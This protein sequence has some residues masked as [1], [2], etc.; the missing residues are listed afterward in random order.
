MNALNF[1]F[2]NNGEDELPVKPT[3]KNAYTSQS[4]SIQHSQT[5]IMRKLQ[6]QI[7]NEKSPQKKSKQNNQLTFQPKINENSK[8]IIE[9][10]KN[11][12]AISEIFRDPNEQKL[13][14]PKNSDI[15]R[16]NIDEKNKKEPKMTEQKMQLFF[17]KRKLKRN[18]F[19]F[20]K[21]SKSFEN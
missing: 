1:I 15:F 18:R 9:I 6:Q 20:E 3:I 14:T 8:K 11:R 2:N 16:N 12:K 7:T 21:R 19:Y 5:E 13:S 17:Q 4:K 10:V